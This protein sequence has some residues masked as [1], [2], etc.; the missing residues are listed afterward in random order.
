MSFGC[1]WSACDVVR[2]EQLFDAHGLGVFGR[3]KPNLTE[4]NVWWNA[5]GGGEIR[6]VGFLLGQAK[7]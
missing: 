7:A 4:E 5:R 3:G 6:N 2:G 1:A